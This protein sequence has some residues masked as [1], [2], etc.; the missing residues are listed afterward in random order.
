MT[1]YVDDERKYPSNMIKGRA[2][3]WGN[4]WSH[5]WTDGNEEE[6]HEMAEKLGLKRSYYQ[7][8]H[9]RFQ[10]YDIIPSKRKRAILLGAQQASTADFIR[11]RNG[12]Q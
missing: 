10:H 1:I 5:M 8:H 11:L 2:K 3:R 9:P 6:L 12:I 7:D 4:T